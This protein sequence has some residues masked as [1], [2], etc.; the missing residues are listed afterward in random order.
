MQ[1]HSLLRWLFSVLYRTTFSLPLSLSSSPANTITRI[2]KLC[3]ALPLA[4]R[5]AFDG[6]V[7]TVLGLEQWQGVGEGDGNGGAKKGSMKEK[8]DESKGGKQ[9]QWRW[10]QHHCVCS[11]HNWLYQR[12]FC[13]LLTPLLWGNSAV[14]PCRIEWLHARVCTGLCAC[15]L[16]ICMGHSHFWG[17]D[18]FIFLFFSLAKPKSRPTINWTSALCIEYFDIFWVFWV[19]Q[20]TN[21]ICWYEVGVK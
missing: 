2:H 6:S 17:M 4:L 8:T 7:V 19:F 5:Q 11:W 12:Q 18:L 13:T 3:R 1:H 10:N 15:Y 16:D 9:H 20:W 14:M 21:L